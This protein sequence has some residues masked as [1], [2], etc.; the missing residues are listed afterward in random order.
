[1][2]E[3]FL[4]YLVIIFAFLVIVDLLSDWWIDINVKES[5]QQLKL[6]KYEQQEVVNKILRDEFKSSRENPPILGK[7]SSI[8]KQCSN[9]G[10]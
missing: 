4:L 2:S 3:K 9:Q 5:D 8:D 1:M 6:Q 10:K 7:Q